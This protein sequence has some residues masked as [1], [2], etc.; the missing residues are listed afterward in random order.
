MGNW[1][2][3]GSKIVFTSGPYWSDTQHS[4]GIVHSPGVPM[5]HAA[6]PFDASTLY[7]LVIKDTR[8]EGGIPPYQEF[9]N[10]DGPGGSYTGVPESWYYCKKS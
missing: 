3:S 10:N 8:Q 2:V 4:V 6:Y 7:T 5:P 9:T 1:H